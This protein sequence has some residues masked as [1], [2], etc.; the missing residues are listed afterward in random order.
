MAKVLGIHQLE[1]KSGVTAEAFEKFFQEEYLTKHPS[2]PDVTPS[3]LKGD[4]GERVGK[5]LLIFEFDSP[6]AR[7]RFFV[8]EAERPPEVEQTLQLWEQVRTYVTTTWT[9]YIELYK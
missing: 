8:D 4:K 7:A 9:D 3:L 5:Y 2:F 1:L 6:E